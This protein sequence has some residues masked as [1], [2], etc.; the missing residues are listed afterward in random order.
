MDRIADNVGGRGEFDR[1]CLD[2]SGH[3]T[4]NND[5]T[6]GDLAIDASLFSK[7]HVLRLDVANDCPVDVY[8]TTAVQISPYPKIATDQRG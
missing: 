4:V 3:K 7:D 8:F 2:Q 6:R 5:G 1:A